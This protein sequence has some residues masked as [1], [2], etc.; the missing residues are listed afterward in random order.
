MAWSSK[1]AAGLASMGKAIKAEVDL[2]RED[3]EQRQR[4]ERGPRDRFVCLKR[5][6]TSV[7]ELMEHQY[8]SEDGGDAQER[9]PL[10]DADPPAAHVCELPP[11]PSVSRRS[12]CL[13][14]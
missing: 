10:G 13:C 7:K 1:F 12:S 9:L 2:L 14:L 11:R 4:R 3:P 8:A 6:K 5:L